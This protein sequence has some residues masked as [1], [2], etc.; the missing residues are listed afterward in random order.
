MKTE[1]ESH[2]RRTPRKSVIWQL[3]Y[4]RIVLVKDIACEPS[5]KDY[6]FIFETKQLEDQRL[7]Q[8]IFME[9]KVMYLNGQC[10]RE[11]DIRI[12]VAYFLM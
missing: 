3:S 5:F 7:K 1:N 4:L 10:M 12:L 8:N 6:I 11:E 9:R 2:S